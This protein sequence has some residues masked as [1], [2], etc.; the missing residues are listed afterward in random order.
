M[1]YLKIFEEWDSVMVDYIG[2]NLLRGPDYRIRNEYFRK[3]KNVPFSKWDMDFFKRKLVKNDTHDFFRPSNLNVDTRYK[4]SVDF[5]KPDSPNGEFINLK[6]YKLGD[7]YYLCQVK[8][9]DVSYLIDNTQ[10]LE[11]FIDID[12]PSMYDKIDFRG[13]D[14]RF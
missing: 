13:R 8:H 3:Y 10:D 6:F 9:R 14:I 2:I 4:I 5:K 1:K 11:K 12:I 7:E